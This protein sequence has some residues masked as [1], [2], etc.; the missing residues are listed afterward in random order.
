MNGP[1]LHPLS[2]SLSI[3]LMPPVDVD[4]AVAAPDDPVAVVSF[5]VNLRTKSNTLARKSNGCWRSNHCNRAAQRENRTLL[6][7]VQQW[8]TSLWCKEKHATFTHTKLLPVIKIEM[9]LRLN[10]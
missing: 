5:A 3:S 6:H 9:Q 7:F 4:V 1:S 8:K 2:F 10:T